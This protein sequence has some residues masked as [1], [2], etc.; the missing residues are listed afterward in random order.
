M[1]DKRL[2]NT[3]LDVLHSPDSRIRASKGLRAFCE[4]YNLGM[5][6][7]ASL[8]FSENDKTEIGRI[9]HGEMGIDPA[10]TTSASWKQLDRAQSLGLAHD[11][12]LSGHSVGAGRLRLKT[13]AGQPLQVAGGNWR[14]PSRADLGLDLEAV[15]GS[16][17]GHDALLVV[18]N[19]QTFEDIHEVG[20]DVT[21]GLAG[22][23]PLVLYRG[24]AQGG[25]R[26]DAVHALIERTT[27]PVYAFVD[28]DPAGLVIA[29][30]LPR[31][32]QVL[33]P[34]FVK[35]EALIRTSGITQRYLVQVAAASY[36]LERMESDPRIASLWDVIRRAGKALPQ[37]FFHRARRR[38]EDAT[39]LTS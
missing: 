13:L 32:D 19:L 14:L 38:G 3:L 4:E 17:I 2:I 18:E 23:N 6:Q 36:A 5:M 9:L 15:L 12:K 27:L 21:G 20:T 30:G 26:A 39:E 10:T 28:F 37:E 24:D 22:L 7:G 29:S 8:A 33:S 1:I 25:A 16:R 35:L 11:E 31:L 34:E